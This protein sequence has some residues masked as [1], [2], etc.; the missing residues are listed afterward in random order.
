M[1]VH[2]LEPAAARTAAPFEVLRHIGAVLGIGFLID[3]DLDRDGVHL[4]RARVHHTGGA[5]LAVEADR[6]IAIPRDRPGLAE[7]VG[8]GIAAVVRMAAGV[9]HRTA[10]GFVHAPIGDRAI[11]ENRGAVGLGGSR[12]R[13]RQRCPAT[14]HGEGHSQKENLPP[15]IDSNG[16]RQCRLAT[17]RRPRP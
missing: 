12:R 17:V 11:G 10:A 9:G 1:A 6:G 13:R 5:A 15:H 8:A 3:P 2:Q 7:G 14:R 16:G 4:Q